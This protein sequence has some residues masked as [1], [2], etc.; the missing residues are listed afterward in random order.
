M[1]NVEPIWP[2]YKTVFDGHSRI[3][4]IFISETF[5]SCVYV[6]FYDVYTFMSK[7]RTSMYLGHNLGCLRIYVTIKNDVHVFMSKLKDVHVLSSQ[8]RMSMCI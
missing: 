8:F 5:D 1:S 6:K 2:L 4:H 7:F 3:K